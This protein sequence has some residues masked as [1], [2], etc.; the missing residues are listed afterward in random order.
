M[1]FIGVGVCLAF[2]EAVGIGLQI[3]IIL[4]LIS[5]L[6]FGCLPMSVPRENLCLIVFSAL[7]YW[8]I[9]PFWFILIFNL[10]LTTKFEGLQVWMKSWFLAE[11]TDAKLSFSYQLCKW[12]VRK[13]MRG[14]RC[15]E[16]DIFWTLGK[17]LRSICVRCRSFSHSEIDPY[18]NVPSHPQQSYFWGNPCHAGSSQDHPQAQWFTVRI[19]R[20]CLLSWF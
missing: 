14:S 18:F 2:T 10:P 8:V 11:T 3:S 20:N 4:F 16:L 12:P 7:I 13:V 6:W 19:H 15:H 1:I 9:S 17:C 5:I